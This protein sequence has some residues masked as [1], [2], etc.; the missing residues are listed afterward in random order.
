MPATL[1]IQS[2]RS[3]DSRGSSDWSLDSA[4]PPAIAFFNVSLTLL[5][6][7]SNNK[8]AK[9]EASITL[10]INALNAKQVYSIRQAAKLFNVPASTLYNRF[11]VTRVKDKK[12]LAIV[13]I[14]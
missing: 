13:I 14:S 1:P 8:H 3:T 6:S 7:N 10:A 4:Q 9:R 2:R 5:A 12:G 11:T